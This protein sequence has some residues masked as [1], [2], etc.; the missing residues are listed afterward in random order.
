[1]L[2]DPA[3]HCLP[4]LAGQ[5]VRMADVI[6][7]LMDREPVRIVRSTFSILTFDADGRLDPGRFEDQQS[8]LVES[9]VA[10]VIAGSHFTRS[11]TVV[12]ASARFD[13]QGGHWVPSRALSRIIEETALGQRPCPRL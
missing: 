12:N 3:K 7:E 13:A 5:R 6:V 8:A 1:M 4:V 2:Q 9:L 10:P 11:P